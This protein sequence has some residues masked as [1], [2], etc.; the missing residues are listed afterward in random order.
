MAILDAALIIGSGLL[1]SL[2]TGPQIGGLPLPAFIGYLLA[3]ALGGVLLFRMR[4]RRR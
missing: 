1:A 2:E 3:L 4:R